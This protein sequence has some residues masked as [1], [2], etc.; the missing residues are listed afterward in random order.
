MTMHI[1]HCC[2][3]M[4][5]TP[6]TPLRLDYFRDGEAVRHGVE[7]A[8]AGQHALSILAT[9]GSLDDAA[10]FAR[11]ARAYG[12]TSVTVATLCLCMWR[13]GRHQGERCACSAAH[14]AKAQQQPAF[15][16]A[17]RA[18][19]CLTVD[20]PDPHVTP[21]YITPDE[22][23]LAHIAR[24]PQAPVPTTLDDPAAARLFTAIQRHYPYSR[25]QLDRMLAVAATF[26]RVA[27]AT[28]IKPAHLAQA[29]QFAPQTVLN[30]KRDARR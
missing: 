27:N 10:Y 26:A 19:I 14:I 29:F 20:A 15:R 6:T 18:D 12:V 13:G 17:M 9:G 1:C 22:L 7:I 24:A 16:R 3:S 5:P 30:Q 8:L 11:T 21:Q 23:R 4:R 25:I 2:G 28:Q